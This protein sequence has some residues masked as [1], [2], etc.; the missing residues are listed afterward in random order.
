[1]A[2]P[3]LFTWV[4]RSERSAHFI[5]NPKVKATLL[6]HRIIDSRKFWEFGPIMFKRVI[7]ETVIGMDVS[8]QLLAAAAG[9][10]VAVEGRLHQR[11]HDA[12]QGRLVPAPVAL[13]VVLHA[14]HVAGFVGYYKSR[15]KTVL[16]IQGTASHRMTHARDWSVSLHSS[17]S[18]VLPG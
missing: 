17:R 11:G 2:T 7:K 4:K 1:M 6:I 15:G 9:P 8:P 3:Q 13:A 10:V 5:T 18:K 12:A 14:Q 16:M